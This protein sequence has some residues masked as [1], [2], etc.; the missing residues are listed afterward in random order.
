MR[1]EGEIPGELAPG[2]EIP[3]DLAPGGEIPGTPK[4]I[5][6]PL[7]YQLSYKARWELVVGNLDSKGQTPLD[8]VG[9]R[10]GGHKH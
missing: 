2:G 3:R 6:S 8:L 10:G 1:R 9:G 5:R 7:L 4:Q